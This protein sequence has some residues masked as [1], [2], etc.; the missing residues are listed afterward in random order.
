[1]SLKD[2][3]QKRGMDLRL[4]H[5]I[6][7]G[8]SWFG[9]WGYKFGRGTYCV[10]QQMYQKAIEALIAMPLCLLIHHFTNSNNEIP[11]IFARYQ[12]LSDHSLVTLGDLF[13]LML[14]L[15]SKLPKENCAID[16]YSK[17]IFIEANCRWS[18]RRVE[19]ATRVI[20][21]A[22]KR[23]QFKWVSRQEVRD[24]ARVYIG[25]TGLLDFV[26]KSLGNHIVGNYLVRRNLN[27]ITK[28][29]EYCLEDISN[30][31]PN[32]E[33]YSQMTNN[34]TR[35]IK[36][37]Y[38]ITRVQLM[39]DL[40]YLY[41]YIF[42]DQK[43]T[44]IGI[45]AA[46]SLAIRIVLDSKYLIK[47][48]CN[49]EQLI[50]MDR[51]EENLN[52]CCT[53]VLRNNTENVDGPLLNKVMPPYECVKL[54]K[55]AT[56]D[57]LKVEVERSFRDIYWGLRSFVVESILK[58][59][60]KGTDLVSGLVGLGDQKLVFSG[61]NKE[62]GSINGDELYEHGLNSNFVNCLCGAKDGD[63]ELMISC[64]ICEK[65]QHTRCVGIANNAKPSVFICDRCEQEIIVLS[66][67]P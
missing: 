67:L 9:C 49:E 54:R 6:A 46:M 21:E 66:S 24:E 38:K 32:Q 36:P 2:I 11:H 48:Y 20:V 47:E 10:T 33:S 62:I 34:N 30:V 53:I 35:V 57:E 5:G 25:D 60:G 41:R 14:E 31:F 42:K 45:F 56:I 16:S 18:P 59:N 8:K 3:S 4:I 1:M 13:H 19:M 12:T 15:K 22:L 23:A 17:G 65:W 63:G 52:L 26:L 37:R 39:K 28:V 27:P 55:N 51:L 61:V 40:F 29:L 44:S 7:Y 64:D 58:F 50:K 43:L